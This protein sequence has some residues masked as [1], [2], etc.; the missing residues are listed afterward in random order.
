MGIRLRSVKVP[1]SRH[2]FLYERPWR[3]RFPVA[4]KRSPDRPLHRL[5]TLPLRQAD[6]GRDGVQRVAPEKKLVYQV[7]WSVDGTHRDP[8][9]WLDGTVLRE[10]DN[11]RRLATEGV[12]RY[13]LVT[14]VPS[15]G[16]DVPHIREMCGTSA[17]RGRNWDIRSAQLE[18]GR[19]REDVRVQGD[20]VPLARGRRRRNPRD[21]EAV[22]RDA[23]GPGSGCRDVDEHRPVVGGGCVAAARRLVTD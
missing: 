12:R 14:N 16:T 7:K 1:E 20:D 2:K 19:P 10:E 3:P 6:G 13:V 17:G 15:T 4:G 9:A 21:Q 8:V 11:L 5:R 23:P 22:R 18:A